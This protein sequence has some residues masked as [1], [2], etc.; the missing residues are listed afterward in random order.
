[1]PLRIWAPGIIVVTLVGLWRI[2]P[3]RALVAG[4][5]V[6]GGTAAYALALW[7][8]GRHREPCPTCGARAVALVN[9]F[10]A[11]LPPSYSF[12]RCEA[13]GAEFIKVGSGDLEPRAS[14][15]FNEHS[16]W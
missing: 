3:G 8:V 13:C 12:H 6:V 1:M 4:I 9:A 10:K 5:V 15:R 7:K 2:D 16:G 14:S 11:N